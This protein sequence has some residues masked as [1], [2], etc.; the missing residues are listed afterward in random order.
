MIQSIQSFIAGFLC[1]VVFYLAQLPAPAP[2][3]LAGLWGIAGIFVG[4]GVINFFK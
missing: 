2:A 4:Y 1:G 3:Q